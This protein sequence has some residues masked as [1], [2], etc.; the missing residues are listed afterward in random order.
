MQNSGNQKPNWVKLKEQLQKEKPEE[1]VF[2][3]LTGAD[4]ITNGKLPN[5]LPYEWK[6]R[7]P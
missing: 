3:N 6:K 2:T 7:R 5:G 1:V 4:G